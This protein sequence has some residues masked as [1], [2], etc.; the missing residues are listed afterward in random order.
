ME[1]YGENKCGVCVPDTI[2]KD[3]ETIK[4]EDKNKIKENEDGK[5]D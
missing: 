5:S 4:Y 2:N 1:T 3:G